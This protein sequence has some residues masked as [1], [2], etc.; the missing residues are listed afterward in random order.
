MSSES[1]LDLTF[2]VELEFVL[3]YPKSYITPELREANLIH[4]LKTEWAVVYTQVYLALKAANVRI[5]NPA[6]TCETAELPDYSNWH[7]VRDSSII[8]PKKIPGVNQ[9]GI[10]IPSRILGGAGSASLSE[11]L[12]EIRHV[13]SVLTTNQPWT[14]STNNSTGLHVHVGNRDAGLPHRTLTNLAL[15]LYA[16]EPAMQSIHPLERTSQW[17]YWSKPIRC[18]FPEKNDHLDNLIAIQECPTVYAL[19][20]TAGSAGKAS[21]YNFR[22][23]LKKGTIEFRQ[24]RGTMDPDE[25]C[26][27]VELVTGL[28]Q[29]CHDVPSGVLVPLVMGVVKDE[30]LGLGGLLRLVGKTH[31]VQ[32]Y[33]GMVAQ[34]AE[35]R[36][37]MESGEWDETAPERFEFEM[38]STS[39]EDFDGGSEEAFDG[40]S[41]EAFNGGSEEDF[42][43]WL[44]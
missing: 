41:E 25:I 5:T 15:T 19:T 24:H 21:A 16:F 26:A 28:M 27:W 13:I 6:L 10:E 20:A 40:G 33:A 42:A 18:A 23:L 7:I 31:L 12:A 29:W 17:S 3:S 30:R 43:T 2:G 36:E 37:K 14:V 4:Q 32:Y 9:K 34:R 11:S 39:E 8:I 38:D 22:T 44:D 35:E 1:P